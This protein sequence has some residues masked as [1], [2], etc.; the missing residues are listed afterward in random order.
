MKKIIIVGATSGL[1]FLVAKSYIEKGCCVGIAGR[2]EE[3]LQPLVEL[4]PNRVFA[5]RIDVTDPH[6]DDLLLQLIREMDGMDL[7]FLTSG[8]GIENPDLTPSVEIQTAKTN[9]EGFIRMVDTAF[10]YFKTRPEGGQLAAVSSVAGIKGLGVSAAYSAT[11]AFQIHYLSAL[12]QLATLNSY[13]NLRI[14]NILPGFTSTDILA[15]RRY[16]FQMPPEKVARQIVRAIDRK[17]RR[18]IID[19]KFK[20]LVVPLWRLIPTALWEHIK[21]H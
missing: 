17:K 18:Q 11:K 8:V 9:C 6:S 19:R 3:R 16:F 15:G 13:R 12:A 20:Y 7:F 2:R 4:A 10:N 1:G 14:T 5:K 21:A